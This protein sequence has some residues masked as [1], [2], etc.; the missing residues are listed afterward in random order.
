MIVIESHG[1][2]HNMDKF[3]KKMSEG[4]ISDIW[5]IRQGV[6]LTRWPRLLRSSQDSRQARGRMRSRRAVEAMVYPGSTQT[7]TTASTLQSFYNT[8]TAQVQVAM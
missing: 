1:D 2:F 4:D 3:L 7:S 6:V 5:R 8:A